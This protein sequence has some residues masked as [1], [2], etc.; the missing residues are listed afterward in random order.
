MIT[1]YLHLVSAKLVLCMTLM[2]LL[3]S[4]AYSQQPLEPLRAIPAPLRESLAERIALFAEYQRTQNWEGISD[5]L[6]SFYSV[7]RER[8][9]YTPEQ[10]HWMI[11]Q[12]KKTRMINF[13]PQRSSW[14]TAVL[15]LPMNKRY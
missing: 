2:A 7:A 15:S 1:Y 6:G 11:E 12:L 14:S 13:T 10:K 4:S 3:N 9:R 8:A 5:L